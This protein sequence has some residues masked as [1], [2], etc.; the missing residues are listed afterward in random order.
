M[1]TLTLEERDGRT[2]V[3]TNSLVQSVADRD[4]TVDSGMTEG[5]AGGYDRLEEL[6]AAMLAPA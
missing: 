5:M 6:L 1:D 2:T 3:R 4:G